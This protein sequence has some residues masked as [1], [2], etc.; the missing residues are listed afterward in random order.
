MF[1]R[2]H[3]TLTKSFKSSGEKN[4]RS[5]KLNPKI[6][7]LKM[8]LLLPGINRTVPPRRYLVRSGEGGGGL[9]KS[10]ELPML[11]ENALG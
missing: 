7:K 1:A 11:P 4:G 9:P 2:F 10:T 3:K 6:V 8:F 5:D